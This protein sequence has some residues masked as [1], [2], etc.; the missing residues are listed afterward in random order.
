MTLINHA[1]SGF[2]LCL[3]NLGFIVG[4]SMTI[5]SHATILYTSSGIY[6]IALSI[7]TWKYLHKLEHLGY[8]VYLIGAFFMLSDPDATKQGGGGPSYTGDLISFLGAGAGA[9]SGYFCA[10]N[11]KKI[12]SYCD[13]DK[14][15]FLFSIIS[16][17]YTTY[18]YQ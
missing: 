18:F 4:C 7:I 8:G 14:F 3:W 13:N 17:F 5:T 12:T 11:S 6:L 1:I 9:V 2:F 16:T 15:I 10:K